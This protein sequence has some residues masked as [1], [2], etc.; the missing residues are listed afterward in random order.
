M[1]YLDDNGFYKWDRFEPL[2]RGGRKVGNQSAREA[3]RILMSKVNRGGRKRDSEIGVG[4]GLGK[5]GKRGKGEKGVRAA[6][7]MLLLEVANGED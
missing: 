2:G 3:K 1:D 4:C 6:C 5:G 7:W